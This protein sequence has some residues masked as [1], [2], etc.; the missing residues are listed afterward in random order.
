MS[1]DDT[2]QELQGLSLAAGEA[3]E[4]ERDQLSQIGLHR[5]LGA[6]KAQVSMEPDSD[7]RSLRGLQA[8]ASVDLRKIAII[9]QIITS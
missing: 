9:S 8:A 2:P 1:P 3:L 6:R 7:G 5:D 4:L